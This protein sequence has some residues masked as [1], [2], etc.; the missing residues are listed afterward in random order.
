MSPA[1]E[2]G[3]PMPEAQGAPGAARAGTGPARSGTGNPVL[4]P[5]VRQ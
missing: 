4:P 2:F 3:A 1:E 5:A